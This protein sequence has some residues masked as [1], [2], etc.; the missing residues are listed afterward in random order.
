MGED[1]DERIE[2]IQPSGAASAFPQLTRHV[3]TPGRN[4]ICT[5]GTA[6]PTHDS[7]T[8]I[9]QPDKDVG[10]LAHEIYCKNHSQQIKRSFIQ[11]RIAQ[12]TKEELARRLQVM[13]WIKLQISYRQYK[14]ISLIN[15]I[16]NKFINF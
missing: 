5:D 1:D 3:Q 13:S 11:V 12:M 6:L 15:K 9:Y 10:Q 7:Q 2:A 14:I 16:I 4:E 8:R